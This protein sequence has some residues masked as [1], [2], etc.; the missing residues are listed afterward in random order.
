VE[1]VNEHPEEWE[2]LIVGIDRRG[3]ISLSNPG[4]GQVNYIYKRIARNARLDE[5]VTKGISGH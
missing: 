5:F 3:R 2:Y 4:S 1:W